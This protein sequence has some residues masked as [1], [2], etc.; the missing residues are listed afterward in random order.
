MDLLF[1]VTGSTLPFPLQSSIEL[2]DWSEVEA[3]DEQGEYIE[4]EEVVVEEEECA[5]K[6]EQVE[7][8]QDPF[9]PTTLIA[10]RNQS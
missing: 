10:I 8:E 7:Q 6:E 4:A 2:T 5:E 1:D 3:Q 9:A